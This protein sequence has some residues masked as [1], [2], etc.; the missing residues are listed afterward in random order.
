MGRLGG[1]RRMSRTFRLNIAVA[2][3]ALAMPLNAC[4]GKSGEKVDSRDTMS[5]R[6]QPTTAPTMQVEMINPPADYSEVKGEGFTISAPGEFQQKRET[7]A[8][9]PMLVLEKPSS[10]DAFPQRVVVI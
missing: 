8:G 5:D 4:G 7:N 9:E 10:I 1:M 6:C 3:L 2:V